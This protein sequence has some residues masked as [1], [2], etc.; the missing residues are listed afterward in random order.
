MNRFVAG[1]GTMRHPQRALCAVLAALTLAALPARGDDGTIDDGARFDVRSAFLEPA[2]HVYQLNATL[3]LALSRSAQQAVRNGVPVALQLD[4]TVD[5]QR[6]FLPDEQVASL[7][8]RW[9]IR[10]HAL[11]ERFLVNNL[12]SGQQTSYASLASALGALSEVRGLPV[13][14]EALIERGQRYE[15]SLR[16]VA[17]IEGGLPSALKFMMFWIDWKRATDWYTWTLRP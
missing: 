5:R 10:Y 9:Q 14:D 8:Q 2:E 15:A 16:V 12:N 17:A 7:V 6:R 11:S 4:I 1:I 3:D 13:I